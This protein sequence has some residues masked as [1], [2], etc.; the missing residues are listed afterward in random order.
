MREG[1]PW[2]PAVAASGREWR[3]APTSRG[4][5]LAVLVHEAGV[6]GGHLGDD[7]V[8]VT[9]GRQEGRTE[10][11]RALLLTK[12]RAR[13]H[14][15]A[16]RLEQ[17][18]GVEGV[19]GLARLGRGRL[20]F[21]G[22]GHVR[23]GVHA[24]LRRVAADA[25]ER[26]ERGDELCGAPLERAHDGLALAC[27]ERMRGL[28]RLRWAHHQADGDLAHHVRAQADGDELEKLRLY[29]R[30]EAMQL[31]V[32]SAHAAFAEEALGDRVEGDQLEALRLGA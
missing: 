14:D 27:V 21:G 6:E 26:V 24:P 9:L 5:V 20:R 11:P 17:G 4:A 16:R 7:G 19:R 31:E 3:G 22:D 10:V 15:D 18:E 8:H 2:P 1:R 12:A 13:H 28:A 29:L 30:V 23:E 25:L 32:A